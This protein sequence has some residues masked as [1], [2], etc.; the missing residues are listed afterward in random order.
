MIVKFVKSEVFFMPDCFARGISLKRNG[1]G[2]MK[3]LFR[4]AGGSPGSRFCSGEYPRSVSDLKERV[5]LASIDCGKKVY[6][7]YRDPRIRV[8]K[9]GY[10]QNINVL[11]YFNPK[12]NYC[13]SLQLC[14]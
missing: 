4:G 14:G 10:M 12:K 3:R 1:M 5:C 13:C 7:S 6:S 11:S 9:D 2:P 8:Y